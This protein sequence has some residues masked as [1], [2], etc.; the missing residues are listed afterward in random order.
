MFQV[1]EKVRKACSTRAKSQVSCDR[2]YELALRMFRGEGLA[3]YFI[4][5]LGHGVGID[6]HEKPVLGPK[7]RDV[8]KS[9]MVL[10]VEPG[11]YVPGLAGVRSESMVFL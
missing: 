2:L 1:V 7:S 6:V 9:G 5:N 8:L 4:H 11:L 10:T 3:K